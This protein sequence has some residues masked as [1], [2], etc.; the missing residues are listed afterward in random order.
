M[1]SIRV[2]VIKRAGKSNFYMQYRDP[3]T[4]KLAERKSTG[5]PAIEKRR[6][7]ALRA[8]AKWEEELNSQSYSRAA[9]DLSWEEWRDRCDREYMP[10]L[11]DKTRRCYATALNAFERVIG[12]P[13]RMS[14]V[15]YALL[16][17]FAAELR[18][19][20]KKAKQ[21]K[22][23]QP[24]AGQGSETEKPKKPMGRPAKSGVSEAT[25]AS[26]LRSLSAVFG[27]AV[28]MR[29]MRAV[30][31]MPR[32]RGQKN[33]NRV[34]MKG[35]PI[36][37][38]E[39]ERML[40]AVPAVVGR[41]SAK[42]W[43][44]LLAGLW[45]SGLRLG[46][47]LHLYWDAAPSDRRAIII[48]TDGQHPMLRIQSSAQKS[49]REQLY[50]IAPEFWRLLDRHWPEGDRRGRVFRLLSKRGNAVRSLEEVSKTICA[51]GQTAGVVVDS[52]K[53]KFASAHDLRRSFG[54]RWASRPYVL[55]Q[56]LKELMRHA[57]ISTTMS[58]YVGSLAD[59]TA[60]AIWRAYRADKRRNR[61]TQRG[62]QTPEKP[63]KPE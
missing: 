54:L 15:D 31:A 11:E 48:V 19:P 56:L 13:R 51:I 14:M 24:P 33:G 58:Y 38:E 59:T 45:W 52:A 12:K 2:C 37:R 35:R 41:E 40:A 62:T 49:G 1:D 55:P 42:C 9:V 5:V 7:D 47:A 27:W 60:T 50:P 28:E 57:D 30:P 32:T 4:G 20:P 53:G 17:R 22:Q 43:R 29:Y 63:A 8:A 16:A 3:V 34:K 18:H 10:T 39:Y 44:R 46:E 61:G 23:D 21:P 25:I 26:Y 36:T 6:R